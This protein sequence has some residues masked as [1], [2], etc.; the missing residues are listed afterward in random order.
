M[1][2]RMVQPNLWIFIIEGLLVVIAC[3]GSKGGILKGSDDQTINLKFLQWLV[4]GLLAP[5]FMH[6]PKLF[7]V[8]A[9]RGNDEMRGIKTDSPDDLKFTNIG[10]DFYTARS[11]VEDYL[12]YR[13][14]DT[15]SYF[16]Q[17]VADVWE[18]YFEQESLHDVMIKVTNLSGFEKTFLFV[19]LW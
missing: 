11:N 7:I 10:A 1:S 9:C 4:N 2:L 12:S 18:K 6:K 13:S 5:A 8:N 19:G 15:G 17:A 16:L 14:A 3:H